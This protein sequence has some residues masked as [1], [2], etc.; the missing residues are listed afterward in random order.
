MKR[1]EYLL[2]QNI[3][4]LDHLK[5][6]SG[7]NQNRAKEFDSDGYSVDEAGDAS[8]G[9][10]LYPAGLDTKEERY[11]PTWGKLDED[12]PEMSSNVTSVSECKVLCLFHEHLR[13]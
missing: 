5:V 11:K 13:G 7:N 12:Y 3:K 2:V 4:R 9:F 10:R 8:G 1:V 6:Q